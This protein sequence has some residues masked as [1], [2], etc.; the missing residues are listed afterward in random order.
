L[1]PVTTPISA[2]ASYIEHVARLERRLTTDNA[3]RQAVG[4]EFIAIGKLE[5][6][7]LRS[8]GLKDNDLVVDVGCGSGRLACQLAPFPG[9]R[10]IGC[11]VVPRLLEY[12]A[13]LCE[14]PDWTFATTNG[15]TIPCDSGVADFVCFFSVFTHLSQ[16]DIYR[17]VREAHRVLKPGGLLVM[18]FLEFRV[19]SHWA[20]FIASVDLTREDQHLNQFIER[21]SIHAWAAPA[22]FD[23]RTIH[24]GDALYI[25]LPEEVVYETGSRARGAASLGQSVAILQK[26]AN[27]ITRGAEVNGGSASAADASKDAS[28]ER[29]NRAPPE[30]SAIAGLLNVSARAIVPARES[31][32][33]GFMVGG[34][35]EQ[36]VLLRVIGPSLSA[37]GVPHP[38]AEP[39]LE[40]FFGDVRRGRASSGWRGAADI[41]AA[42]AQLGAFTIAPNSN[43]TA[44]LVSLAPGNY[45]AVVKG[46]TAEDYGDVL[47]EVYLVGP[48]PFV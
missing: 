35:A 10:F 2:S 33:V 38:L 45:T 24:G 40:L 30:A 26:R 21:D 46:A 28:M 39:H 43:D 22:G 44:L 25:P 23:V 15:A 42:S 3:L 6:F 12:A 48:A 41:A 37:F 29:G 8:R 5:Y 18:S 20:T 11:D 1:S 9:I 16:E 34:D 7:L 31:V 17:Y 36:Q 4:G 32:T 19:P 27:A 47:I 13:E 14:R